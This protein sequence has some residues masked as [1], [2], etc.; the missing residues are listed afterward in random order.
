MNKNKLKYDILKK[1]V[2]N[3]IKIIT[4]KHT[5]KYDKE[6]S[7]TLLQEEIDA[8]I[9]AYGKEIQKLKRHIV[10]ILYDVRNELFVYL[11]TKNENDVIIYNLFLK[12]DDFLSKIENKKQ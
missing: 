3:N 2:M 1:Y 9:I 7:Y 4:G 11:I 10:N 12:L 5:S 6:D 8:L